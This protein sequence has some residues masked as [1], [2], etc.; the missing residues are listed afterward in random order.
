M[1]PNA[2]NVAKEIKAFFFL[3]IN[4]NEQLST[5][6]YFY[7]LSSLHVLTSRQQQKT[8]TSN[9]LPY[10]SELAAELAASAN[11]AVIH[12]MHVCCCKNHTLF[13]ITLFSHDEVAVMF[14]ISFAYKLFRISFP[15][16][17]TH[18]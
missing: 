12:N 13:R 14:Q 10:N 2:K 18:K 9:L 1:I 16:T 7:T 6:H 15:K 3:N 8:S 11:K 5:K 17:F 4:T